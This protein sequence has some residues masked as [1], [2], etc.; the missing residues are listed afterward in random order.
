MRCDV[1][2]THI[3]SIESSL[4]SFGYC[5]SGLPRRTRC[6]CCHGHPLRALA[7]WTCIAQWPE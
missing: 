5:Y 3:E 2:L 7:R 6:F 1:A 4:H